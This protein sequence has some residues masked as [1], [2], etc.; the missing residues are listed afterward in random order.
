MKNLKVILNLDESYT[1]ILNHFQ[2]CFLHK[3]KINHLSHCDRFLPISLNTLTLAN[4]N[5]GDLNEIS[6]LVNLVNLTKISIANNPCVNMTGSNMYPFFVHIF[7]LLHKHLSL[8]CTVETQL[9]HFTSFHGLI[10][11]FCYSDNQKFG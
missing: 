10:V 9:T 11:V 5:I 6:R 7:Y 4:N 1:I 3:N 8:V 2:E